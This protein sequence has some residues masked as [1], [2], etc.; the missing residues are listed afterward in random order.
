M[1]INPLFVARHP[2]VYSRLGA[3]TQPVTDYSIYTQSFKGA[4]HCEQWPS[5]VP[6]ASCSPVHSINTHLQ[7]LKEIEVTVFLGFVHFNFLQHFREFV[8][9]P[10]KVPHPA[11]SQVVIHVAFC[12][13]GDDVFRLE[14]CIN[15]HQSDVILVV[16]V[17]LVIANKKLF[18]GIHIFEL[19]KCINLLKVKLPDV[20]RFLGI[21]FCEISQNYQWVSASIIEAVCSCQYPS[22]VYH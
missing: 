16:V 18:F 20:F 10:I 22:L 5:R 7:I 8:V 19:A 12:T 11:N 17:W 13:S 4:G 2:C 1:R 21:R 9:I 3:T 14:I 6:L 15:F